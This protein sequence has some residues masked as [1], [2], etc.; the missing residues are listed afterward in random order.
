MHESASLNKLSKIELA[1]LLA[2]AITLR[3]IGLNR[4]I[5]LDE[6][7]SIALIKSENF[8]TALRSY[9]HPPFYFL[10]LKLWNFFGESALYL[11]SLS[12]L[13]SIL[14]IIVV[15]AWLGSYSRRAALW[16]AFICA[17]HPQF[18][19]Y[20]QE[21]RGYSLL[22]L[23]SALSFLYASRF[24]KGENKALIP[25]SV[26][27]TLVALT[28]VVGIVLSVS[29][30]CY[31][32]VAHPKRAQLFTWQSIAAL[33]LPVLVFILYFSLVLNLSSEHDVENWWITQISSDY[34]VQI[35]VRLLALDWMVWPIKFLAHGTEAAL[36]GK[37]STAILLALG[38]VSLTVRLKK[39][40][41]GLL[42]AA[43]AFITILTV[44]SLTAVPVLIVRTALPALIAVT[45][46]V[47]IRLGRAQSGLGSITLSSLL[48]IC[49][50]S[51]ALR[52]S[53]EFAPSNR[54]NWKE[55]TH[56]LKEEIQPGDLVVIYAEYMRGIL[57][58]FE[59]E[60]P[61]QQIRFLTLGIKEAEISEISTELKNSADQFK[62][63]ILVTH[64][65]PARAER[66]K[67]L[68]ELHEI[69]LSYFP[70]LKEKKG[71]YPL[72]LECFS[73]E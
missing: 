55:F 59:P 8:L 16:G 42:L 69:V 58:Y 30:T 60:L 28:H 25:M 66:D 68:L 54:E 17:L 32:L 36:L 5:W 70:V 53:V 4:D 62:R 23:L 3:L 40:E 29:I 49:I 31:L 51:A 38:V 20:A 7:S 33:G 26:C 61:L 56:Q 45:A 14:T 27:L 43:A 37:I 1:L 50:V 57:L 47:S 18:L 41:F 34:V 13:F 52:W 19:I 9:D 46:L 39:L 64:I 24:L 6:Y 73:R 67:K 2:A 44:Y 35:V 71:L 48:I 21:I 11:R 15:V 65:L 72:D 10:L 22:I 12:F 63:I